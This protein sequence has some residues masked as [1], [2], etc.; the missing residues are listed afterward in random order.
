MEYLEG[1]VK[2]IGYDE[3]EWQPVSAFMHDVSDP[4]T[5]YNKSEAIDIGLKYI[6]PDIVS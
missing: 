1:Y 6:R 4:C 2:Y 3:P 5:E